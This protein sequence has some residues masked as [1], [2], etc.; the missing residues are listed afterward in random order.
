VEIILLVIVL[1]PIAMMFKLVF[2]ILGKTFC[3]VMGTLKQ[4]GQKKR[5]EA[6]TRRPGNAQ[7][8]RT[9]IMVHM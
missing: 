6:E 5:T 9:D 2:I 8:P 7:F 1:I 4:P 3:V